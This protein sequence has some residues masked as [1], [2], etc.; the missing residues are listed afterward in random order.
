MYAVVGA[1]GNTGRAVAET[2]LAAGEDVLAIG[3]SP[4]RL[5]PLVAAGAEAFSGSVEDAQSISIAFSGALAVYCLLPLRYDVADLRAYQR[6]VGDALA[7]AIHETGVQHV[8]F[9]S[10]IGAQQEDGSGV[11][12]LLRGLREQEDR[13]AK[14]RDVN[15]LILRAGWLMENLLTHIKSIRQ[16]G[17][18]R[19]PLRGDLPIP[20]IAARD[21][22]R[23]VGEQ[24]AAREFEGLSIQELLGPRDVTLEEATELLGASISKKLKYVQLS[25][26]E[27]EELGES[28]GMSGSAVRALSEMYRAWNEGR[29]VPETGRTAEFTGSTSIEEFATRFAELY[30]RDRS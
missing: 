10:C 7:A 26:A 28:T 4:E 18:V 11:R 1:T 3:R 2:L 21:V 24:L 29:I 9:L 8:V 23:Y 19:T 25:F 27:F 20:M 22:G 14:L 16:S 13:F 6:S 17:I 15:L 5:Q 30:N 12:G